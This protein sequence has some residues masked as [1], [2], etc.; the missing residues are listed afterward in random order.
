MAGVT[1]PAT[2]AALVK[3]NETIRVLYFFFSFY[4]FFSFSSSSCTS[5]LKLFS[6]ENITSVC[7]HKK[8][9][10]DRHICC[11]P[12]I[13]LI[14]FSAHSHCVK[15]TFQMWVRPRC[16]EC[17]LFISSTTRER[18]KK[19]NAY[20]RVENSAVVR[21]H[22]HAYVCVVISKGLVR[23]Y[24]P[25]L[26]QFVVCSFLLSLAWSKDFIT[27]YF[28]GFCFSFKIPENFSHLFCKSSLFSFA[29]E[30]TLQHNMCI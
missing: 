9:L 3:A 19:A 23:L 24:I 4:N 6:H 26:N 15:S 28:L 8:F 17:V 20:T 22:T 21:K 10:F 12:K 25:W 16:I 1:L 18:Q 5:S 13:H 7:Y 27:Q 11:E 29:S 2:I 14:L 30:H